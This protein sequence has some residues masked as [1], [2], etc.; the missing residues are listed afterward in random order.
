[1]NPD[2]D[3][4]VSP[5]VTASLHTELEAILQAAAQ[6]ADSAH[7]RDHRQHTLISQSGALKAGLQALTGAELGPGGGGSGPGGGGGV[8]GR[9]EALRATRRSS[10]ALKQE[11]SA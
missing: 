1:M 5:Q 8:D 3:S 9:G 2:P 4:P 7:T 11:V 6:L 10:T